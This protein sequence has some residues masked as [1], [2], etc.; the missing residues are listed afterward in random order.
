MA[1]IISRVWSSAATSL[2]TIAQTLARKLK[3][4]TS[5]CVVRDA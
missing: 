4:E 3:S 1:L 2:T 5:L